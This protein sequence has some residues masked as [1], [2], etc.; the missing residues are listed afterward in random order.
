MKLLSWKDV[1]LLFVVGGIVGAIC[2]G[3]HSHQNILEYS[4]AWA[5]KMAWWV[6]LLFAVATLTVAYG[7]LLIDRAFHLPRRRPG[8]LRVVAGLAAFVAVYAASAYLPVE[9]DAKILIL[10]MAII[11]MWLAFNRCWQGVLQMILT[12]ILGCTVEISLVVNGSFRYIHPG[13]LGIPY[14]LPFL[15]GAASI[16]VGNWARQLAYRK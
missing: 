14:W 12:S 1:L 4:H 11:G 8:R 13:F 5:F 3:F 2:D 16:G 10:D 6:P 7:H 9:N 15:Y